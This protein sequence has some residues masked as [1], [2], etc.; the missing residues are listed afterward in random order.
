MVFDKAGEDR[1]MQKSCGAG[2]IQEKGNE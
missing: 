2:L 1:K